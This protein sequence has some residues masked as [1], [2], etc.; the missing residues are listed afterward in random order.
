VFQN[1]LKQTKTKN[2]CFETNK[3]EDQ[4]TSYVMDMGVDMDKDMAMDIGMKMAIFLLFQFVSNG[5]MVI[6]RH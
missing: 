5:I 1:I 3:L 4:Y 6:S 2:W